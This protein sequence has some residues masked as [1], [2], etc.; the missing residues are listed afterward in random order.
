MLL[1]AL[2]LRAKFNYVR[3]KVCAL[4]L[5][6]IGAVVLFLFWL[7]GLFFFLCAIPLSLY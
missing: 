2:N 1:K 3:R 7:V 5:F 6:V 4:Q